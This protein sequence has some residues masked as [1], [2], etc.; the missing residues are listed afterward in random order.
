LFIF[1][2]IKVFDMGNLVLISWRV[3]DNG[4]ITRL[5][6]SHGEAGEIGLVDIVQTGQN[7]LVTA[8]SN[9]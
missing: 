6:D 5:D 4:I 2:I 9:G 7:R 1:K 3:D 8:V